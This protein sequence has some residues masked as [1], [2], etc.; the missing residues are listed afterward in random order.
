MADRTPTSPDKPFSWRDYVTISDEFRA[1]Q[2]ELLTKT[3]D[4]IANAYDGEGMRLLKVAFAGNDDKIVPIKPGKGIGVLRDSDNGVKI[5]LNMEDLAALKTRGTPPRALGLA[6]IL[7]HELYHVAEGGAADDAKTTD[8]VVAAAG[9]GVDA[10]ALRKETETLLENT[11][12]IAFFSLLIVAEPDRSN[13]AGSIANEAPLL[14]ELI[15]TTTPE[16][17]NKTLIDTG[18]IN[19]YKAPI[20]EPRATLYAD[21]FSKKNWGDQF[22]QR[23]SYENIQTIYNNESLAAPQPTATPQATTGFVSPDPELSITPVEARAPNLLQTIGANL[24]QSGVTIAAPQA[25]NAALAALLRSDPSVA[26][27]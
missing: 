17:W 14:A 3:L 11:P 1:D 6:P 25:T 22:P 8:L 18:L 4:A 26:L 23:G 20:W 19:E 27:G 16:Q 13:I 12:T 15:K 5:E 21:A 7:V 24:Q 2:R 9:K 10:N